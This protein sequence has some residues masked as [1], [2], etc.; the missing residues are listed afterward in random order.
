M[1]SNLK[2]TVYHNHGGEIVAHSIMGL[3]DQQSVKGIIGDP[4]ICLDIK[5]ECLQG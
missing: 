5:H 2:L 4:T 3:V 1:T